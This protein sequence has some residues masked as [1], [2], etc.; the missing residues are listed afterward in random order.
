MTVPDGQQP[1]SFIRVV[2]IGNT[3]G[4][5]PMNVP[6]GDIFIHTGNFTNAGNLTELEAFCY[7]LSQLPHRYKVIIPGVNENTHTRILMQQLDQNIVFL[8]GA[9]TLL[10]GIRI[11]AA[12]KL[13]SKIEFKPFDAVSD[14]VV[15]HYPPYDILD[16]SHLDVYIPAIAAQDMNSDINLCVMD[17]NKVHTKEQPLIN[18]KQL[19]THTGNKQLLQCLHEYTPAVCIFG[20]AGDSAGTKLIDGCLYANACLFSWNDKH[21]CYMQ[22][23]YPTVIDIVT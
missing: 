18:Y 22:Y 19:I 1:P 13:N 20:Y 8:D 4:F 11:C 16:L 3:Y 10:C 2:A 23:G 6:Y 5:N 9:T 21:T 14:I 17:S 7:W 12:T 15:S